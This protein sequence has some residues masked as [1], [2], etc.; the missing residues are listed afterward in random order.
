MSENLL[1][2]L[3]LFLTFQNVAIL[4]LGVLIGAVIGAIPGMTTPMGVALAFPFTFTM[5]PVTGILLLLG[6]FMDQLAMMLLTVPIFFPIVLQLGFDPIW[7]GVIVVMVVELG[8]ITP[9]VGL[10]VYTVRSVA[11]QMRE[12]EGMTLED[13]FRGILPFFFLS[14]V[15]L[16]ILIAVPPISTFLPSKMFG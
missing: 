12:G 1:E 9:P 7:F 11:V 13:I 4:F 5:H 2:A 3:S 6:M 8:L 10:N 14:I 15:A 16:I